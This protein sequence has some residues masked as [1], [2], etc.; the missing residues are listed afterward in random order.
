MGLFENF[1]C[2]SERNYNGYRNGEI[3]RLFERQSAETDLAKRRQIVWDIDANCWPM[4]PGPSSCG[5]ATPP[6]GSPTSRATSPHVNSTT[7]NG[8]RFEDVWLER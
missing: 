3:E 2:R 7:F 6:A 4:P 5:T 8:A 1:S